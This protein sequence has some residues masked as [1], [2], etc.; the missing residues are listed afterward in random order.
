MARI[1]TIK[2]EFW[3]SEQILNLSIP[4]RL[5]FIGLW[6]F[7][8]DG[9]N[10]VASERTLKAEVF[11]SDDMDSTNVRRMIDELSRQGL[12][13]E[14]EVLGKSYW[15]VTGWQHQKIDKP[16]PKL[17]VFNDSTIIR[18]TFDDHSPQEG[19][20]REGKVKEREG[21]E[22][23][24]GATRKNEIDVAMQ[25]QMLKAFED[26]W[27]A[28]PK[29]NCSKKEALRS[30]GK[31]GFDD[32]PAIAA[33]LRGYLDY[34]RREAWQKPAHQTTWL[35]QRRWEVEYAAIAPTQTGASSEQ[36]KADEVRRVN[37]ERRNKVLNTIQIG[38]E[39]NAVAITTIS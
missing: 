22:I 32:L 29:T 33:G 24:V 8:D 10:H 17:P 14:Y 9:G 3:T 23:I 2:P 36:Q 27:K 7:C 16:N 5:L 15:H 38:G 39:T 4:A 20:G 18:R 11:P 12:I 37:E 13:V 19:K 1:R 30:W 21:K 26:F 34:L 28:Y 31:I 6:N 35:N 25:Y